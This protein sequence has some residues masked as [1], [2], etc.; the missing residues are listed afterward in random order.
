MTEDD[1][2][3]AIKKL[4]WDELEKLWHERRTNPELQKQ[5]KKGKFFEYAILR[6]FEIEGA[7]VKYPFN[8]PYPLAIDDEKEVV[9]QIDGIIYENGLTVLAES[10]DYEDDKI[11]IEP[12]AKLQVR[13]KRRPTPVIGCIFTA[14]GFTLPAQILIESLM[15]HTI[16]LWNNA[17]IELCLERHCFRKGLHL[18]Y[19][20]MIE[21][22]NHMFNLSAAAQIGKI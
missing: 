13:L 4:G 15:P 22:A 18:K 17:D 21:E 14:T 2:K 3:I 5:W 1:Y 12:L 10:K 9:E 7:E 6:A 19:R 16:L 20:N 11:D 8:V